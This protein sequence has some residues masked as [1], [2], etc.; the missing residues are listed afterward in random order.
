MMRRLLTAL[1]VIAALGCG[2]DAPVPGTISISLNTPN[3][4]DGA[5]VVTL[6]GSGITGLQPANSSYQVF[7]R[8]VTVDE[9]RVVVFGNLSQGPVLTATV[10]NINDPDG[11]AALLVQVA[12]R[13]NELQ[14]N[15]GYSLTVETFSSVSARQSGGGVVSP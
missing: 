14:E 15:S 12:N 2:E 5:M 8:L 13:N 10:P 6:S 9:L 7:Q 4:N 11:Y 1:A 3:S